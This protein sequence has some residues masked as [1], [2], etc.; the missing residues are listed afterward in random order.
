MLGLVA[1]K[2][3]SER[4]L[5][6]ALGTCLINDTDSFNNSLKFLLWL[7]LPICQVYYKEWHGSERNTIPAQYE[8]GWTS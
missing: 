8:A 1:S 4:S 6:E 5:P 3:E 2:F 7:H